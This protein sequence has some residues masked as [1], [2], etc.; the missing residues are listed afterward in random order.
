MTLA[1]NLR[2]EMKDLPAGEFCPAYYRWLGLKDHLDAPMASLRAAGI[3]S[4]FRAPVPHIF[5]NDLIVGS[6]F[7][8][9]TTEEKTVV[10]HAKQTV[11]RL[12]NRSFITNSDHY[13][14]NYR[15]TLAVGVPGLIVE[16][17]TSLET[18]ADDPQKVEFLCAMRET[19]EAFRD[20]IANYAKKA[21]DLMGDPDYHREYLEF[22][23]DNCEALVAGAPRTFA[24]GLQ[25]VW[26]CHTAFLCEG[27]YAMALG[28][29]D[30][31]LWPLYRADVEAGRLT[32]EV[33][34]GL[35]ENTFTKISTSDVVN[36]AIGGMHPDGSTAVNDLSK[37]ALDAVR[38]GNAPGPN[39]SARVSPSMP[40]AFLLECLKS[41]GTG[42]GYPALMNDEVNIAALRRMGYA[43]ADVYDYSMVGC[44]E[45]FITGKQPPWSD[46]RFDAPRF[47]DYL[48]HHGISRFHGSVG[49]DLGDIETIGTMDE[50]M[51][52]FETLM[53]YGAKE[54]VTLF[55]AQNEGINQEYY[56]EPFLSC[57]AEDCIGRGLDI[58]NG[59]CVYPSVHGAAL[60]G[61]G[62]VA[63]SLAAIEKVVF[64]D[65]AATLE[66]LR[67]A[68]DA[69]FV[70]FEDLRETLLAAPKYGN[71]DDFVDKYAVWYLDF[72]SGEFDKYRTRDGG[73][74]YVAM[75]ANTSN[76][77][78]GKTIAATPDGRREGE[79]LS[80]AASPT[81]G[82]DTRGVT[83]TLNSVAKP[84]YTLA[85][86]GTVVNQKFSPSMF[87]GAKLQKLLAL[88]RT[89]FKKGGQELQMNATSRAVLKDAMEHPENY[90]TLVVRVSGFSDY[91]VRLDRN[92][93]LDILNRTQHE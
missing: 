87:E 51:S 60:M 36:I 72:L 34:T 29:I 47:F 55:R 50:F 63:D 3:A 54:Y 74:F 7:G 32:P 41:I 14:P 77:W 5:K 28:R 10:E 18:Y 24:Q 81:Y 11:N 31:Y 85:A 8:L 86:C 46:G 61:V 13:A 39:L 2:N 45:N 82:R 35:L 23:A 70:G 38:N 80:D 69:N 79:P 22:I 92:V 67:D 44:I 90:P 88:V 78:A 65:K 73:A 1:Q 64:L 40:D 19:V 37:C 16:I 52:R 48:F 49:P 17:E 26:F 33:A 6:T 43:E 93:Q 76:I 71:N 15:H 9:Y 84:N 66:E 59:G 12:G 25:L 4:L 83:A 53:A 75:A 42:L 89:Y 91:Y 57:F 68:M 20:M 30:Q 56:P 27:R 21:R 62:T 58:N